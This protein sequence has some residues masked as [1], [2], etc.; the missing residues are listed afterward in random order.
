[1][2][3]NFFIKEKKKISLSGGVARGFVHIGVLKAFDT[4]KI[5]IHFISGSSV[6]A[7][8]RA[9]T[10]V[11][12]P[13]KKNGCNFQNPFHETASK[14]KLSRHGMFSAEAIEKLVTNYVGN[15]TFDETQIPK[16]SYDRYF[17]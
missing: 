2:L 5:Q 15:K 4:F 9:Y 13:L 8:I 11:E 14:I 16:Y 1:M 12:Y 3:F 10:H 6:G 17:K 7:L